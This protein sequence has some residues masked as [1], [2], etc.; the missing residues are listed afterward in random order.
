[1]KLATAPSKNEG[2]M[3]CEITWERCSDDPG[4]NIRGFGVLD[5]RCIRL[6]RDVPD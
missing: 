5:H 1:M 2:A 4:S 3:T 6:K